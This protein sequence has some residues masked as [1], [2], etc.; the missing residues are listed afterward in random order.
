MTHV[1]E[2]GI[3]PLKGTLLLDIVERTSLPLI[4]PLG[5]ELQWFAARP[6]AAAAV[7]CMIPPVYWCEAI[8]YSISLPC[9]PTNWEV[10]YWYTL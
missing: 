9:S 10:V 6:L 4:R 3:P 7:V 2:C 5:K 1:C 8:A